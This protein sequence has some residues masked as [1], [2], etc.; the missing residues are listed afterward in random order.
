MIESEVVAQGSINGVLNSHHYNRSLRTHKYV[1]KS[2]QRLRFQAF[3]ET[4]PEEDAKEYTNIIH[5]VKL[6]FTS[7][8]LESMCTSDDF[9]NLTSKYEG[10]IEEMKKANPTFTFW[11][12]YIEMVQILLLFVRATRE[13]DWDG[14]GL[15][16]EMDWLEMMNLPLTHPECYQEVTASGYWTVQRQ[17]GHGFSSRVIPWEK[18]PSS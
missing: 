14:N 16:M 4:L 11:S 12:S 13:S 9:L 18:L 10:F 2:L 7:E 6:S 5:P 1:Y 15:E 17:S 8:N 3:M